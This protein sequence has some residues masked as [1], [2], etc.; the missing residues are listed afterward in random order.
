ML[1]FQTLLVMLC[2]AA[3][4]MLPGALLYPRLRPLGIGRATALGIG[5][6]LQSVLFTTL[7]SV[8][9]YH[10]GSQLALGLLC[11]IAC[12][13]WAKPTRR[14]FWANW[15]PQLARWQWLLLLAI[16]GAYV[17][18]AFWLHV[19][20]DVDAQGFGLLVLT[21]QRSGS[22]SSLAPFQPNIRWFYS[23]AHFLFCAELA[24]LTKAP[25]PQVLLGLG[26]LQALLVLLG[27]AELGG[28]LL[29]KAG[30]WWAGVTCA[31]GVA[32]I[33]T[34]LDSAY[35][36]IV[37]LWLTTSVLVLLDPFLSQNTP[38]LTK[39]H[40]K[41]IAAA[42]LCLGAI[43]LNHP[44][45]IVQLVVAYLPFYGMVWF[46]RQRP[47]RW[48]Y[49][50]LTTIIPLG[51]LL[52]CAPWLLRAAP[53]IAQIDVHERQSPLA[54]W[55]DWLYVANG[56]WV[57]WAA[58]LGLWWSLRRRHWLDLFCL[59]WMVAILEFAVWGN[60]DALS[61][62]TRL[63]PFQVLYPFGMA[64]HAPIIPLPLLATSVL[65]PLGRWVAAR[66]Q[67]WQPWLTRALSIGLA[68]EMAAL[69]SLPFWAVHI[70][71]AQLN[72]TGMVATTADLQ[73][74]AWIKANTPP[75]ARLLNAPG[76]FEGQW[77]P[78]L[79]E[80]D[81]V[82]L[83]DQLF[84]IHAHALRQEWQQFV[85]VFAD[86]ANPQSR[87]LLQTS[88]IDYIVVPQLYN[89]PEQLPTLLRWRKPTFATKLSDFKNAPWLTLSADFDG[90]QVWRV[91]P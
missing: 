8:W 77:A 34:L 3:L 31:A 30:A 74:Y 22:I 40:W 33:T 25:I 47:T 67:G 32:L 15:W 66:W 29:G 89:R 60:L 87:T 45:T 42:A 69:G 44:D 78:V 73:A 57:V 58:V 91:S 82:Y 10:W 11:V 6:A 17:L 13:L 64:W 36:S 18:P 7:A 4:Y 12:A 19:P 85:A 79:A 83:R 49:L 63:D 86:P 76:A 20:L 71:P 28:K 62:Q 16:V 46:C 75:T 1:G 55:L 84:Y 54:V 43:F 21:V 24:D 53:L 37:A 70:R 39:R 90:A 35:T 48:S 80:R 50:A 72:I 51:G 88:G 56:V 2:G 41:L 65:V 9:R 61:R 5:Y 23:P 81:A 59:T 26:H 68:V 14:D 38:G 52:L 27:V